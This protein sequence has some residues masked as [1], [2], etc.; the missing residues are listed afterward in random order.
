MDLSSVTLLVP[1]LNRAAFLQ[2]LLSYCKK[3]GL[4][5]PILIGDSSRPDQQKMIMGSIEKARPA[6]NVEYFYYPVEMNVYKVLYD[7]LKK[8]TTPY[9]AFLGDDDF[10]VPGTLL[11]AVRF[12]DQHPDYSVAHGESILIA[13]N[14]NTTPALDSVGAYGQSSH[15][16]ALPSERL[17]SH[18]SRYTTTAFSIHRTEEMRENHRKVVEANLDIRMSEQV[19]SGLS[20]IQG[21][22]KKIGGLLMVR[23]G[24]GDQDSQ[25]LSQRMDFWDWVFSKPW[26]NFFWTGC[27]ILAE[28]LA[29]KQDISNEAASQAAYQALKANIMSN[30]FKFSGGKPP[31]TFRQKVKLKLKKYKPLKYFWI[32]ARSYVPDE[33]G[34]KLLPALLRRGSPYYADMSSVLDVIDPRRRG[35]GS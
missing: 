33:K 21:K 10:F 31:P 14:A 8:V 32:Y 1:T 5:S 6:V 3:T 34:K 2:E 27:G 13:A 16:Q 29:R 9:A 11:K 23:R 17:M 28:E 4:S 26:S 30:R 25:K 22:S 15:E 24:H 7:L 18:M 12:L 35:S 20:L 19:L